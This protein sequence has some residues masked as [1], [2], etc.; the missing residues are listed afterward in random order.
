MFPV[1]AGCVVAAW[2]SFVPV[3]QCVGPPPISFANHVAGH[4]KLATPLAV[5][6][7]GYLV[8]LEFLFTFLGGLLD[9]I[10]VHGVKLLSLRFTRLFLSRGGFVIILW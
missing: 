4:S 3:E 1:L 6:T 10:G 7:I 5:H 9:P 2:F 8:F